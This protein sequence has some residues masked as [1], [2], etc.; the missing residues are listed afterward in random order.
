MRQHSILNIR[1]DCGSVGCL[2][3][4][5]LQVA[6][7]RSALEQ[8]T[9]PRKLLPMVS[10]CTL[11]GGPPPLVYECVWMGECGNC[12]ALWA[13]W[14]QPKGIH[15]LFGFVFI[16]VLFPTCFKVIF[17]RMKLIFLLTNRFFFFA[18]A[19]I[20]LERVLLGST[21]LLPEFSWNF[22]N[23]LVQPSLTEGATVYRVYCR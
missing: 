16:F 6:I 3:V 19:K 9:E 23:S 8:G 20:F 13:A 2:S 10:L 7:G 14:M 11:H 15:W 17:W 5:R 1:G 18:L 4:G 22:S 21:F 12:K